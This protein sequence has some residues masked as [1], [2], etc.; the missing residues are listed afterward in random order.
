MVCQAPPPNGHR[1]MTVATTALAAIPFQSWHSERPRRSGARLLH[2]TEPRRTAGVTMAWQ[3]DLLL[4]E[5]FESVHR[6]LA[7]AL[8]DVER[9]PS[10]EERTP[11]FLR[12][13]ERIARLNTTLA[14]LKAALERRERGAIH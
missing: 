2:E 3:P 6:A 12:R 10:G 14:S 13:M 8:E 4:I 5:L 7:R 1:A 9:S 11:D